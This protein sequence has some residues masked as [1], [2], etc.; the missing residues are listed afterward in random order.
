META[1][2]EAIEKIREQEQPWTVLNYVT[3]EYSRILPVLAKYYNDL[4]DPKLLSTRSAI[5]LSNFGIPKLN[6]LTDLKY[7]AVKVLQNP[8]LLVLLTFM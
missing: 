6:L 2:K 4:K 7:D 8:K 3:K 1:F 5:L